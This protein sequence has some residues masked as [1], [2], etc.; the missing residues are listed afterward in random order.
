MKRNTKPGTPQPGRGGSGGV[1]ALQPS[2]VTVLHVDDD[3]ND[4][5]LLKAA[6][7]KAGADFKLHSVAGGEQAIAYLSGSAP[8]TAGDRYPRPSLILLDLK[9]PCIS[10][11]DIL[12]WIRRQPQWVDVPIVVLSGSHLQDDIH[13]AYALGANSYHVKPLGFEAL[14]ELVRNISSVWLPAVNAGSHVPGLRRSPSA[15]LE[16][17]FS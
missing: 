15:P 16:N 1:R 2:P 6:V 14:V 3:S 11:F 8:Y 17:P 12:Q 5:E 9:M 13:R 10:G 7:S 4:A